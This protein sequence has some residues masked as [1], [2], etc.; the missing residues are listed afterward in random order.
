MTA[1]DARSLAHCDPEQ[2]DLCG[3]QGRG[4]RARPRLVHRDR[5]R[6]ARPGGRPLDRDHAPDLRDRPE[7]GLLPLAR[8]P[9]RAAAQRIPVQS[10]ADRDLP[11]G[12]RRARRRSRAHQGARAGRR[13][14]Q[15]RPGAARRLPHGEHG[16][17]GHRR[18]RLR[19]PL[20][21]RPVPA[22]VQRRLAGRAAGGLAGVRQSLG[23]RAARGDLRDRLRRLGRARGRRRS[24]RAPGLAAGG[25]GA[26]DRVR[27]PDRRLGR[28]LGEHAP[29][30]VGRRGEPDPP[31][32]VQQRR[33][34][35][36]GRGAG[37]VREHRAHP[38]P[39]RRHAGRPGAAPDPG[40][41]LHLRLAPGPVAA[42]SAAGPRPRL[43]A[44]P[45]R[46]PAQRHP[47]GDRGRRADA[48]SARRAPSPLVRGLA[49]HPRLHRLHQSHPVCRR[50]SR[51]GRCR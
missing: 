7:A 41:F 31:R 24:V 42:A 32:P 3:R 36:R 18:L 38:V 14:R 13:A 48:P 16:D 8:V 1:D 34:H 35:G 37:A 10:A 23:V 50:R 17:R 40:V 15:W 28:P 11:G 39:E 46:D 43:A 51:T 21:A 29:A 4:P 30:M 47:S 27:H 6:R 5:A 2:A 25:A 26:R 12:A 33:L 45:R 9:D 49:D 22:A 44:R 20:S 19:H